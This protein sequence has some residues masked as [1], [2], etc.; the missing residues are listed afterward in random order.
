MVKM[1]NH[2]EPEDFQIS[3]LNEFFLVADK[4]RKAGCI[5]QQGF[6]KLKSKPN[7]NGGGARLSILTSSGKAPFTNGSFALVTLFVQSSCEAPL[8]LSDFLPRNPF[9]KEERKEIR[10]LEVPA[11]P[12]SSARCQ[13]LDRIVQAITERSTGG[14][15]RAQQPGKMSSSRPNRASN[16]GKE[17]WRSVR[18][19][20]PTVTY[21]DPPS[22]HPGASFF[23]CG[24]GGRP[25]P[26]SS[27][28]FLSIPFSPSFLRILFC[29]RGARV[30]AGNPGRHCRKASDKG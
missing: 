14:L 25:I 4:I 17:Q 28:T 18:R 26:P 6:S 7:P 24:R 5:T 13:A 30:R 15:G 12:S 20:L 10:A 23:G 16:H 1:N 9:G 19:Q 11:A 2:S 29:V 22:E 3:K 8:A 21:G 27:G